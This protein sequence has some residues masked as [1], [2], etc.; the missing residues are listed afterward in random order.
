MKSEPSYRECSTYWMPW[1]LAGAVVIAL[2]GSP[3]GE[4]EGRF[5]KGLYRILRRKGLPDY[6]LPKLMA[7][8]NELA[9]VGDT[10]KHANQSFKG[11]DWSAAASDKGTRKYWL[12]S[13]AKT[14]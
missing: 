2:D 12:D 8:T 14:Y 10:F 7:V 4:I 9:A 5:I 13:E 11:I 6:A 1:W 3:D